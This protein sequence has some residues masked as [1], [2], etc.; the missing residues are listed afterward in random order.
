MIC[1]GNLDD[2]TGLLGYTYSRVY[3]DVSDVTVGS[4]VHKIWGK[5]Y[6]LDT[7]CIMLSLPSKK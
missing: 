7:E 3:P 5:V 6:E 1:H 2:I 4:G